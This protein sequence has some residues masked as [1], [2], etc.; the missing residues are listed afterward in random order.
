MNEDVEILKGVR[1]RLG[2]DQ[3]HMAHELGL[4]R[5]YL[6]Q[7]ENGARPIQPWVIERVTS[8]EAG[9]GKAMMALSDAVRGYG[10]LPPSAAALARSCVEHLAQFLEKAG[11]D[12]VRLSWTVDELHRRFPLSKWDRENRAAGITTEPEMEDRSGGLVKRDPAVENAARKALGAASMPEP[13]PKK[14]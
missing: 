10:G 5:S 9:A 2:W 12:I 14:K 8:I 6:S 4:N 11:A 13:S 7:L 1:K 3:A